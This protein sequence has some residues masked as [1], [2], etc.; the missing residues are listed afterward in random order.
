MQEEIS[1]FLIQ[2]FAESF[3]VFR[4]VHTWM[5]WLGKKIKCSSGLT[6]LGDVPSA[7]LVNLMVIRTH[8]GFPGGPGV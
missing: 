1:F 2:S 3:L 5:S 7:L 4:D 6:L 8:E